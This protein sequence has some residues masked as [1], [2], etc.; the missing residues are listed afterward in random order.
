[1]T[2]LRRAT[3]C[4][5]LALV[6]ATTGC[7]A[8]RT[9][10]IRYYTLSVPRPAAPTVDATIVVSGVTANPGYGATRMAWRPS[11]YRVDYASF[12]RWVA[13]PPLMLAS[14]LEDHLGRT[15]TGNPARRVLVSGAI[16]RIE[17]VR[18]DAGRAAVLALSLRAEVDGRQV[19]GRTWDEREPLAEADD[20]EAVAAALSA[21]L[22]RILDDFTT[23]L[24]AALSAG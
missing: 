7:L 9:P 18:D 15:A 10:A 11:P 21:A 14:V 23:V 22:A 16:R 2:H 3:A 17:A 13:A 4:A 12:H 24:A 20:A 1:M 5:A 8:R 6:A 19:V